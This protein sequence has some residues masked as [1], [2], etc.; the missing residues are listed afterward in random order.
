[1]DAVVWA[2]ALVLGFVLPSLGLAF[3]GAAAASILLRVYQ[4]FLTDP[5]VWRAEFPADWF[6]ATAMVLASCVSAYIG[7]VLRARRVNAKEA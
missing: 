1:M 3:A 7:S 4:Y 5:Q 6:G 2:A